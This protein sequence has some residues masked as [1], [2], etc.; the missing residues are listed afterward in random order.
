TLIKKDCFE[1]PKTKLV[2]IAFINKIIQKLPLI[3]FKENLS[4]AIDMFSHSLQQR[5]K[6]SE[7]TNF[8]L[9]WLMMVR[10]ELETFLKKSCIDSQ[11]E[12]FITNKLNEIF[13][14]TIE[15]ENR[16]FL[17]SSPVRLMPGQPPPGE[18]KTGHRDKADTALPN[19]I[20]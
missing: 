12:R 9:N 14:P 17:C 15:A 8:L 5:T 20:G 1:H 16:K 19:C 6:K 13:N 10:S 2:I 7:E 3:K 4:S 11:K 18:E